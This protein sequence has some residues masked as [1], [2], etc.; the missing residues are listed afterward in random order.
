MAL[1]DAPEGVFVNPWVPNPWS[2][3]RLP[4]EAT[5]FMP[6]GSWHSH[7]TEKPE[8]RALMVMGLRLFLLGSEL[9]SVTNT[10]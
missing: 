1:T 9:D 7:G 8:S 2:E 4:A 6:S 5:T 10:S 3:P